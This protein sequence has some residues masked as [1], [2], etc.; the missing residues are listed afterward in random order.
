MDMD[1]EDRVSTLERQMA[2]LQGSYRWIAGQ[3]ADT[4]RLVEAVDAKVDRVDAK[5]DRVEEKVARVDAKVDAV[6][7]GLNTLR[8]D[9]PGIVGGAVRDVLGK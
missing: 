5:V 2:E 7:T 1:I 3:L 4:H 9:L 8:D 6:Q